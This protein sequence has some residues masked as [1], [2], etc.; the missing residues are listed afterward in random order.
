MSVCCAPFLFFAC[1]KK[2]EKPAPYI[3]PAVT[4][5][6]SI[7]SD[8]PWNVTYNAPVA[9]T[10]I[11]PKVEGILKEKLY[12]D[13]SSVEKGA[14]LFVMDEQPLKEGLV[15]AKAF[16]EKEK[17]NL[18]KVKIKFNKISAQ[19]E[20]GSGSQKEYAN[21]LA[22]YN[23]AENDYKTAKQQLHDAET[24]LG[25]VQ[26][27]APMAG[28]VGLPLQSTGTVISIL[29][30]TGTLAVISKINPLKVVFS[31]PKNEITN[32][33]EWFLKGK[34]KFNKKA[35]K[36]AAYIYAEALLEDGTVYP[37]Q[38]KIVL[39][40]DKNSE[41][42][43]IVTVTAEFANPDKIKTMLP[44]QQVKIRLLNTAYKEAVIIPLSCVLNSSV[45]V[46]KED[47]TAEAVKVSYEIDQ[48][49][50]LITSGL[51]GG[52]QVVSGGASEV[53]AGKLLKPEKKEFM[54]PERYT[55]KIVVPE[56][57]PKS[58]VKAAAKKD[59]KKNQPKTKSAA[60]KSSQPQKKN[61]VKK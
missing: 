1:G 61:A 11:K 3:P 8:V 34:I 39:F 57:K 17:A 4:V 54:L 36:D 55:V 48:D 29:D 13:G 23:K 42:T 46:L 19:R 21:T 10:N 44:G 52:E 33:N 30:G 15:Q 22:I 59:V 35:A 38:G 16:E 5:V 45:Y 20:K 6:E 26:V 51:A 9:G 14:V 18:E 24:R 49:C 28:V 40:D 25:N 37:K 60:K 27:K 43:G 7:K 50:A 12:K 31:M 58:K 2:E 32:F 56:E 41:K 47:N 53:V